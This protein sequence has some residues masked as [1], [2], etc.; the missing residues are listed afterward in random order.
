M[1]LAKGALKPAPL[2]VEHVDLFLQKTLPGPVLDLACGKGDN[3]IFLAQR[4]CQVTCC[5]ISS[6]SLGQAEKLAEAN[7]A[8]VD[9]WQVDLET[10]GVNPL[11]SDEYGAILV[12]RYLHRPLLECIKKA[13]KNGGLLVYETFT[14]EQTRFGKPRNPDFLL[15]PGELLQTFEDWEVIHYFEGV[16][17]NPSRAVAEIVCRKPEGIEQRV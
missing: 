13:L 8:R 4:G 2:L 6:E 3:G 7:N 16:R 11:P 17:E 15:N 14:V 12:F 5:D 10:D 9:S 1:T